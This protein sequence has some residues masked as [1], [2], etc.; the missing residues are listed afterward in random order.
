[1]S[2]PV[3]LHLHKRTVK[4][5]RQPVCT[6]VRGR[7]G[8]EPPGRHVPHSAAA[9]GHRR[10][11]NRHHCGAVGRRAVLPRLHAAPGAL[12]SGLRLECSIR[13]YLR[14]LFLRSATCRARRAALPQRRNQERDVPLSDKGV[15]FT[16]ESKC[17]L[18]I[19]SAVSC[20]HICHAT[21]H[22]PS[23]SII[24]FF[25]KS[26]TCSHRDIHASKMEA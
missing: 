22:G 5:V 15:R 25:P 26:C 13:I 21:K 14:A 1:M 2:L 4:N 11:C 8:G 23:G 18:S 24:I 17:I 12:G 3:S 20:K 6:G 19:F 16:H 7:G 10:C 9:D